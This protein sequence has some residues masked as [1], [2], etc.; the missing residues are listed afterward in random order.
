MPTQL[1]SIAQCESGIK[2]F[3]AD[4]SLVRDYADGSHV[5]VFQLGSH[6]IKK[7]KEFG[8][9]PVNSAKD[10]MIMGI[11]IYNTKGDAPWLASKDCWVKKELAVNSP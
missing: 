3:Y 10:N 9:D 6:W 7:A 5:G 1:V 4:G 11:W 2:Q 8:L